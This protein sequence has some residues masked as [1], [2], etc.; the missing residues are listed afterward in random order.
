IRYTDDFGTA[1][2]SFHVGVD[3][4]VQIDGKTLIIS[5]STLPFDTQISIYIGP[6]AILNIDD[7]SFP[8]YTQ[9]IDWFYTTV[10]APNGAPTDI[11]LTAAS[12]NENNAVN[13]IIGNL[14]SIDPNPGNIFTYSLVSGSGSAD[15]ANFNINGAQLRSSV[16]F[17][18]ETKSSYSVRV[19]STDQGG[20]FFEKSFIISIN[21]INEAPNNI[22]LSANTVAE[23]N[24]VNTVIGLLI[25]SDPDPGNTFVYTMAPSGVD[26]ASFNIS[27]NQ[28]RAS[29]GF[30][31]ET[32]STYSISVRVADQGG[33][34]YDKPFTIE[35]T[36]VNDAPTNILLSSSSIAENNLI[37]EVVGTFSAADQDIADTFT[38]ELVTGNGSGNNT[39]FTINGSQLLAATVFNFEVRNSYSIRVRAT[40]QGGLFYEKQFF[41]SI[42]DVEEDLTGPTIVSFSPLDDAIDVPT[43]AN[44]VVTFNENIEPGN[45]VVRLRRI[46]NN[47]QVLD[48]TPATHPDLF[49][50]N[51]NTLTIHL[52]QANKA[53]IL[54]G[55]EYYVQIT[56]A[57]VSD[58]SGNAFASGWTNAHTWN[59]TTAKSDQSI[60]FSEF[61]LYTF[62]DPL[63]EIDASSSSNLDLTFNSSNLS[64]A[65]VSGNTVT[66]V[67][68]GS[69]TITASQAGN[70]QYNA[71]TAVQR[72]LTVNK[73]NQT[74]TVDAID[75]KLTSAGSFS[76]NATTISNLALTYT[77]LSGPATNSG[78]T[79]TLDGTTGTVEIEVSQAGN[80]NYNAASTTVSFNVTD[81]AKTDQTIT[82]DAL[83]DVTFGDADFNLTA[84][85][86]SSLAVT[87]ESSDENVAMV[88]GSTVTIVGAGNATIT[89]SQTGDATFN[90]APSVQQVLTVNKADQTISIEAIADK[91]TTD[92]AFDVVASSTSNLA[93]IYE[94]AGPA[95]NNGATITLNG[96]AGT[97]TVTVS[98]AGNAN[99]N[100]A[101]AQ[102]TFNVTEQPAKQDQ[103]ITIEAIA[104]KL[105]TDTPFD[106]VASTTSGLVL[107]YEVSGPATIN[108][109]TITL[110]GTT[111][112]VTV[113]VSQAGDDNFNP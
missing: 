2:E 30:N 43:D 55:T 96:T 17:D 61:P 57:A 62:G 47:S 86:S 22:T 83:A 8:G 24:A 26:N 3:P 21:N 53:N 69:T 77:V 82:F 15:N 28:L 79:I 6:G 93:L 45:S 100:A 102:T 20:L 88:S 60:L 44:L 84:T 68:A 25:A 97:I 111:G 95:T 94:V 56:N 5:P 18:F 37:N 16:S 74:I 110:A 31:F 108:G 10:A 80:T 103:T 50:I 42:S 46:T 104:D 109:T 76:V 73:A 63:F 107:T 90:P 75:D 40:D 19:R 52:T 106:V 85:A 105:T 36:D 98:Q 41:I 71:A 13:T 23:N 32:N 7:V 87:Y 99:Y 64:V 67:G 101:S 91:L 11:S 4:Q 34:F 70:S 49:S 12:I 54:P 113:T 27:G 38:Y 35:V 81:P 58:L 39:D 78:S 1:L 92:A 112:T 33:L 59:F 51:D 14:S 72:T 48:G 66:I 29:S 9:N 89:A 65:T